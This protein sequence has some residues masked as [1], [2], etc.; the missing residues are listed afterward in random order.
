MFIL[1]GCGHNIVHID[2]GIGLEAKIPIPFSG[3]DL[4]TV[5]IGKIDS[6]TLVLRGNSKFDSQIETTGSASVNA[7]N[8]TK[9]NA[10]SNGVIKQKIEFSAGAQLNEG[11][12]KDVLVDPNISAEDKAK[13]IQTFV[14]QTKSEQSQTTK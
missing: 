6:T 8:A 14:Q 3:E 4:I 5:K 12:L 7:D 11:Y 2:N 13:I 1:T 10:G 9:G